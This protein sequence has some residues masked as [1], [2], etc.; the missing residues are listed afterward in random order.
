MHVFEFG[1]KISSIYNIKRKDIS[2][3]LTHLTHNIDFAYTVKE[4]IKTS[5]TFFI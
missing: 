4:N 3:S 1:S 2:V 5:E